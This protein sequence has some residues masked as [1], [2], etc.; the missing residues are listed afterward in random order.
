MR[1][2]DAQTLGPRWVET[3]KEHLPPVPNPETLRHVAPPSPYPPPPTPHPP[4]PTPNTPHTP[5][6]FS[7]RCISSMLYLATAEPAPAGAGAGAAAA[8][9]GQ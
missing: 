9:T 3:P 8:A 5:T 1:A 6:F 4:I 2:K 7:A